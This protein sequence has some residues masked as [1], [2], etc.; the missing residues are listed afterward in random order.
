M[1]TYRIQK[2]APLTVDEMDGNFKE[3]EERLKILET[4]LNSSEGIGQILGQRDSLKI[5]GTFGTDFGT[6]P[7]PKA[8]F[9]PRGP[10]T[11]HTP[12]QALDVVSYNE[13]LYSCT[14]AHVSHTWEPNST[15]FQEILRFSRPSTTLPLYEKATLPEGETLGTLALLMEK[16]GSTLIFFD[17]KVW[18]HLMKGDISYD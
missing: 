10:W 13:G 5:T 8:T 12:Y 15:N 14:Q 7:L 6:F 11:P 18:K 2:G 3:L 1:I 4:H 9:T 16:E 17:G